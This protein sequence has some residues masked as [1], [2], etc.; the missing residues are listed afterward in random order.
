VFRPSRLLVAT[1]TLAAACSL[2]VP[3]RA[4]AAAAC[5]SIP[6]AYAGLLGTRATHGVA[7][8][9]TP[10][11]VPTV[12]AGHVAAWVG[13]GGEGLG[14]DGTDEWLQ[15]G[16]S[17]EPGKGLALYYEVALPHAPPVYVMVKGHLDPRRS[18]RVA[19]V[20]SRTQPGWWRV[21]VGGTWMTRLIYLPDSHDAWRP[22]ATSESWNGGVG[23]CNSFAFHFANLANANG[24]G[25]WSKFA[26]HHLDSPG[27]ELLHR[28]PASFV[29][30][31]IAPRTPTAG[32][33]ARPP[34]A[35]VGLEA[36]P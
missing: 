17:A 21:A 27:L 25:R 29:A 15:A 8:T 19:V 33:W 3:G 32:H 20:E 24:A 1:A 5:G 26:A 4:A 10:L 7:A 9:I 14:P 2:A 6:Y 11:G 18:Y 30:A 22:V 28:T 12:R 23:A 16:I 36:S 13:V 31:C 35:H 34:D